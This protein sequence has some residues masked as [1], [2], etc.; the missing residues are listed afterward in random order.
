MGPLVLGG[1]HGAAGT[2]LGPGSALVGPLV[3]DGSHGFD[4]LPEPWEFALGV[5][6][7]HLCS[8]MSDLE[9]QLNGLC[10]KI[11]ICGRERTTLPLTHSEMNPVSTPMNLQD[12]LC[13][14]R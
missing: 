5:S 10:F 7:M 1:S 4:P 2:H 9:K 12:T 14:S 3:L 6:Y 11:E 13:L 8:L